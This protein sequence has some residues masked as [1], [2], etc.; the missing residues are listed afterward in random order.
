MAGMDQSVQV[1]ASL[2]DTLPPEFVQPEDKQPGAT[3]TFSGA[4]AAT[5][6]PLI[7]MSMWNAGCCMAEAAREWGIF[8]VVNHGV[9]S[10][11]VAELQRVGREFFDLPQE[12]KER[13]ALD[14]ASERTE[15]YGSTLGREPDDKKVWGDFLF[16]I[17]APPAAVNVEMWPKDPHGYRE[18]N[19]A[20][21]GHM[22]RLT[23]TL[24]E[25]LSVELGLEQGAMAEALGGD[26]VMFLQKINFYPP[27]PQPELALGVTP[28]TDLCALTVLVPNEVQG[29]QVSKD[30]HWYDVNYVHGALIVNIGDQIEIFSNGRYKAALHRAM[31]SKEKT[32]MSWPVFLE[33]PLEQVVG[34][35]HQ[36]VTD[37]TPAKYNANTFKHYKYCKFNKL[38]L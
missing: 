20:Y 37:E 27:C 6:L 4:A 31:V 3:T 30:G 35:H 13:Y 11:A 5:E 2:L 16:N 29:L 28:H 23:R 22:Q 18:A 8:Q 15:G 34:P 36:L 12:E 26:D 17:V 1:L 7:D 38:P 24:L 32:R 21:C 14:P 10:E 19:E 33:P 9:P 25:S